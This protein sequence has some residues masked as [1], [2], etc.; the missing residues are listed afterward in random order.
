[1]KIIN[2]DD[3]MPFRVSDV[4]QTRRVNG[5]LQVPTGASVPKKFLRENGAIPRITVTGVNN[6]IF[7]KYDFCGSNPSD[8]RVYNNFIS[9]S[10]LGTVFYQKGDA[11]LDMKVH[12]LK[13]LDIELNERTGMF[14]VAAIKTSLRKS[15]YADQLSSTVLPNLVIKLPAT[16]DGRPNFDAMEKFITDKELDVV[17]TLSTLQNY[18]GGMKTR[19]DIANWRRFH[20]Y[21]ECLFEIDN[22][23]KMDKIKMTSRKPS[24]NFI[25]RA[26]ANNGV[27]CVVDEIAEVKPYDAG[28]LTISLGGEYLGSCFVQEKPFYTSQNVNVLI[29]RH[30]MSIRVKRFIATV[31]FREGRLHYKAFT[32]ELNRHM[33]HDFSIPLPSCNDG[34]PDFEYMEKFICERE[35][36]VKTYLDSL[37]T[38]WVKGSS[39]Y[40]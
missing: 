12:C 24:I 22:G 23:T 13:P 4:F 17:R 31:V 2:S 26:N 40:D 10:F 14:L 37:N 8:Y 33:Q 7:G 16:R 35:R 9:V 27:T 39:V 15:S 19:V 18:T 6:G 3:W 34:S 5:N 11:S 1:M 30:K 32:D 25:G 38:Y 21:D 36:R 20:L 28:L 29:P